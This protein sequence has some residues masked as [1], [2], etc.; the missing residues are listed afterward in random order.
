MKKVFLSAALA[1]TVAGSWAF[2]PKAAA[3]P[4]GYMIVIGRGLPFNGASA[5]ITTIGPDGVITETEIEA[6]KGSAAKFNE[7]LN[8]LHRAELK[9]INELRMAGYHLISS[10]C[11]SAQLA[12]SGV[13]VETTYCL[14]K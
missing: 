14:S 12:A 2:Y 11:T 9:K 8:E 3:E 5:S 7:S 13:L 4:G 1:L 10:T 6:E